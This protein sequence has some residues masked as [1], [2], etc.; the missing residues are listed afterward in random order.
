VETNS[1]RPQGHQFIIAV[2]A[3]ESQ[4]NPHQGGHGQG[5]EHQAGHRKGDDRDKVADG[6]G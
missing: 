2:E 4:Q 1:R 6:E 5:I 3:H